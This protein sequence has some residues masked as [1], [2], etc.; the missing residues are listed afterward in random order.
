MLSVSVMACVFACVHIGDRRPNSSL[1]ACMQIMTYLSERKELRR[2]F[3]LL[4]GRHGLKVNDVMFLDDL[5]RLGSAQQGGCSMHSWSDAL[6]RSPHR[7]PVRYQVVLTK[8]DLVDPVDLAK[9]VAVIEAV[10]RQ[11]LPM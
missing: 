5:D 11:P 6:A 2:L 10:R 7:L 9:R 3:V 1:L 8:C 4:D